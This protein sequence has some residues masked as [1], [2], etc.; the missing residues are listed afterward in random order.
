[1][2]ASNSVCDAKWV[3]ATCDDIRCNDMQNNEK[4]KKNKNI[5]QQ[6]DTSTERLRTWKLNAFWRKRR[7]KDESPEVKIVHP[8]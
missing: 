4:K 5:Y 1:M 2:Y 8:F 3:A 7:E 6:D